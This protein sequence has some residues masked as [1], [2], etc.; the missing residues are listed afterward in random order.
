TDPS[1]AGWQYDLA[2]SYA[3]VGDVLIAQGNLAEALK[4]YQDGLAARR[5]RA[6]GR[7]RDLQKQKRHPKAHATW[8]T[9]A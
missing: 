7:R 8:L 1:N 5:A 3:K 6:C 2:V 9:A 4:A